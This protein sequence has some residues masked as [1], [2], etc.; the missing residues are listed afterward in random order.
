MLRIITGSIL[1][2]IALMMV[3]CGSESRTVDI[4]DTEAKTWSHAEEF[5][6]DNS[7]TLSR[8]QILITLRYDGDYVREQVPIKILTVSPDSMVLEE[9]FTLRIPQLADMRPEEHTFVYRSNVLL[10]RRGR[11]SFRLTPDE[12]AEGIAS[13]G[14]IVDKI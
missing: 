5:T 9:N 13:V 7:D 2:L 8:R 10:K 12:P 6:Y 4:H 11:Y 3:A 1:S 14:I